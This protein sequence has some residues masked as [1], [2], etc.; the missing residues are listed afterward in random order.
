MNFFDLWIIMVC[1]Y[2]TVFIVNINRVSMC[3]RK[4]KDICEDGSDLLKKADNTYKTS[5]NIDGS[6][7]IEN[8]K[9]DDPNGCIEFFNSYP[10]WEHNVKDLAEKSDQKQFKDSINK[11]F[12]EDDGLISVFS[13]RKYLTPQEEFEKKVNPI[14]NKID[15]IRQI[16]NLVKNLKKTYN[17]MWILKESLCWPSHI[18]R[19]LKISKPIL[20]VLANYFGAII[21]IVDLIRQIHAC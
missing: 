15:S 20:E 1:I 17:F 3:S 6:T 13:R 14:E 2:V 12:P 5:I 18:L 9:S 8:V 10:T 4:I 11:I 7:K 16:I 21:T 19:I